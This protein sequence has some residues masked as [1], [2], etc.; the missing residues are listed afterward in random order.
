MSKMIPPHLIERTWDIYQQHSNGN[1]VEP[2][3]LQFLSGFAACMGVLVGTLDIGI[4][5]GTQT[6]VVMHQLMLEIDK[7]RAEITA[8]EEVARKRTERRNK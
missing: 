7:Y 6:R 3:K 4:P 1:G 2:D 5:N 8:L